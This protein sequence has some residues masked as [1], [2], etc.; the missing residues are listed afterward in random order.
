MIFQGGHILL[1]LTQITFVQEQNVEKIENP[2]NPVDPNCEKD[3][4]MCPPCNFIL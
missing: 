4:S 1:N 3:L 2:Q